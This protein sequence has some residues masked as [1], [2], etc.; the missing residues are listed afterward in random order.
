MIKYD[1]KGKKTDTQTDKNT[2]RQADTDRQLENLTERK[3]NIH[4]D[5]QTQTDRQNV[6]DLTLVLDACLAS[7]RICILSEHFL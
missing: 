1:K 3:T 2:Y 5:R 6:F 4:T 7:V